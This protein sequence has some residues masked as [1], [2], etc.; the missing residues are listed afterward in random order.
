LGAEIGDGF[1]QRSADRRVEVQGYICTKATGG[2][3]EFGMEFLEPG[4]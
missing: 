3:S 2:S 1:K 4:G